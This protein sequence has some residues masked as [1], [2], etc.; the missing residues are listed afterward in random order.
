M[1]KIILVSDTHFGVRKNSEV[2][3]ESQIKFID[4]QFIPYLIENNIKCVCWLGDIFDNRSNINIK[5]MN[6]VIDIF[7]KLKEFNIFLLTGNHDTFFNDSININSIKI[8][9]EFPNVK[10]IEDITQI[11]LDG[12]KITM[13]PWI[14]DNCK[15][16]KEFKTFDTDIC[17]GHF[18][19][20]GFNFNK[21]K[22]SEDGVSQN[23]FHDC[24]KVFSGHFHIRNTKTYNNTEIIYIGS[25]YQL[26]RND[27]DECRGFTV[28][29]L[30]DLSYEF[31]DNTKSL[32]YIKLQYPQTFD[33]SMIENNI[34]DV[35][36]DYDDS[37]NEVEIDKYIKLIE[38]FNP[39]ISPSIVINNNNEV[40]G[41]VDLTVYNVGSISN[42]I[43]EYVESLDISNKDEINQIL[44]DLYDNVKSNVI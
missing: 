26:T 24:K 16:I 17:L 7:K 33:K 44:F 43:S 22:L 36:I 42:L 1:S 31:I 38:N 30:H 19:I 2:F 12:V 40:D 11:V 39:A 9:S 10:I 34:V 13:V 18:N 6:A 20:N 14:V 4:E 37:Y 21:F 27:A 28:L 23:V 5:I 29:D 15:F 41:S 25:P 32:K 8:F 35:H 3:L